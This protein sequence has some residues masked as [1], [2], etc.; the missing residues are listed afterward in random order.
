M[1]TG[2]LEITKHGQT[3]S[4]DSNDITATRQFLKKFSTDP[5]YKTGQSESFAVMIDSTMTKE[6]QDSYF[7]REF[8]NKI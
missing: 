2:K 3:L 4:L 6:I 5:I 8:T 7:Q 1:S